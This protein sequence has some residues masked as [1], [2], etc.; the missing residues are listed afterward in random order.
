[1]TEQTKIM[2]DEDAL[3]YAIKALQDLDEHCDN[4]EQREELA[5]AISVLS[6]M[7]DTYSTLSC[8]ITLGGEEDAQA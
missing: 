7:L 8:N 5:E 4:D 2:T 3:N 6:S 1:M